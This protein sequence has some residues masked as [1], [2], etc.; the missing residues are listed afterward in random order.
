MKVHI[1]CFSGTGG[2][3]RAAESLREQ[4]TA[5]GNQT[6]KEHISMGNNEFCSLHPKHADML[7]IL[8]PVHAFDAPQIV[9]KWLQEYLQVGTVPK[10]AVVSVSG[11]GEIG[12]NRGS[13]IGLIRLL[14]T[15]GSRVVH[16]DMLIM[17]SN[18]LIGYHDELSMHLLQA[19]RVKCSQIALQLHSGVEQRCSKQTRSRVFSAVSRM[20]QRWAH[21]FALSIRVRESCTGC[22]ICS[23][24][25]PAANIVMENHRPRFRDQCSACY[26]CVYLCPEQALYSGNPTVL[27]QGYSLKQLE[28]RMQEYKPG[29]WEPYCKGPHMKAVRAYLER[30]YLSAEK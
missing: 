19:I 28:R 6:E 1:A 14:E 25:C 22:E 29:R 27:K 18:F 10:S 15:H 16:E 4:L 7:V 20:E 12:P 17:P 30:I 5:L 9:Y 23:R 2:T 24:L 8:F 13:R 21:R 11:G 26:G 3:A